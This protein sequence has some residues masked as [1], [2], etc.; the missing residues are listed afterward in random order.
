[1]NGLQRGY[2]NGLY[3]GRHNGR[4]GGLFAGE[5]RNLFE[6]TPGEWDEDFL[7]FWARTSGTMSDDW[8][9]SYNQ[10]VKDLKAAGIWQKA[11]AF[12]V[13][14]SENESDARL[15][16]IKNAHTCQAYNSPTFY[17]KS[18]FKGNGSSAYLD[19]Q[20]SPYNNGVHYQ[21]NDACQAVCIETVGSGT[22]FSSWE[23]GA[24]GGTMFTFVGGTLYRSINSF[25]TSDTKTDS[26]GIAAMS[27]NNSKEQTVYVAGSGTTESV[28]TKYDFKNYQSSINFLR[29]TGGAFVSSGKISMGFIG[30]S[31]TAQNISD[32]KTI[33]DD[34]KSRIAAL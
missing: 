23:G 22:Y 4:H 17:A 8:K 16:L 15:N 28:P 18:G 26:E 25:Y 20:F 33:I 1:M 27:R 29:R 19:A 10:L 21:L 31:L 11:D 6:K 5:K 34:H 13:F 12:Y 7:A 9:S 30:G 3:V 2:D 32:L 14:A 24:F